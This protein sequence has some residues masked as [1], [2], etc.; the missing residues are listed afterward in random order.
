MLNRTMELFRRLRVRSRGDNTNPGPPPPYSETIQASQMSRLEQRPP[1]SLADLPDNILLEIVIDLSSAS[2]AALALTNRHFLERLGKATL[3]LNPGQRDAFLR[4]LHRDLVTDIYCIPCGK[5]HD[6]IAYDSTKCPDMVVRDVPG[7]SACAFPL[8]P[9]FTVVRAAMRDATAGRR[10][11]HSALGRWSRANGGMRRI[12]IDDSIGGGS[13]REFYFMRD[14]DS[15]YLMVK[16]QFSW[17]PLTH[18]DSARTMDALGRTHSQL[19]EICRHRRWRDEYPFVFPRCSENAEGEMDPRLKCGLQHRWDCTC[20]GTW[21]GQLRGCA[22][23]HTDYCLSLAPIERRGIFV[24]T[25]WKNAGVGG[26]YADPFHK[27]HLD[28]ECAW[29]SSAPPGS[30]CFAY[31]SRWPGDKLGFYVPYRGPPRWQ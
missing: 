28:L 13:R 25:V 11:S 20:T 17:R 9:P 16:F 23:C 27:S 29:P 21:A 15:H 4:Y 1:L 10:N 5:L 22:E 18:S 30:H 2:Q 3:S 6:P 8:Y 19:S 26:D 24:F 12:E 7:G 14:P 31:E